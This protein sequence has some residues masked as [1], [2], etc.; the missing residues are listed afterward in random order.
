MTTISREALYDLVW[1]E[2]VRTIALRMGV[3]DVWLKKCCSKA[4]IPVPDRGYYFR[5]TPYF[6]VSERIHDFWSR[7]F[8]LRVRGGHPGERGGVFRHPARWSVAAPVG[9]GRE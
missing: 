8:R 6:A 5:P 4:D 3:S 9:A 2:P 7:S 1:T